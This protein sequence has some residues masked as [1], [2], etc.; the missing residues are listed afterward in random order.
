MPRGAFFCS[1]P[2]QLDQVYGAGRRQRVAQLVDL[3]D[4]VVTQ[5][6]LAAHRDRLKDV[7]V[8]FS[9]WGMPVLGPE[10]L[11]ALPSLR[12]VFYAAGSVRHFARPL[13]ERGITVVSAWGANAVPVAEFALAQILLCCKGYFHNTRDCREAHRRASNQVFRGRGAFGETIGLIGIG[14]VATCLCEL[15]RPFSLHVV[16]HDPYLSADR[17]AAL[18][19][20]RVE[21]EDLFRR[22]YVVS[23]HLPNLPAT[24]AMLDRRLFAA[25]RQDAAFINTGRGAQVVEADLIA[26]LQERPDLT[27]LLD[28]TD[29]EPPVPGSPLYALPNVHLSSHIAGSMNDE[30]VRMADYAIAEFQRWERREPLRYAVT[31]DMLET[32]A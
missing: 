18:G 14:M 26:V 7:E 20:E 13:L 10:D 19:G 30:V 23:N 21:L 17:A 22:A 9:T 6:N 4:T 24:R 29:P 15:L 8:V 27:A 25:M 12:A 1:S 31:L 28:V 16:G 3:Y 5:E 11:A 2:V 32:M